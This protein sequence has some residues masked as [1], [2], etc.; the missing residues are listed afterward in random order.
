[1]DEKI[2]RVYLQMSGKGLDPISRAVLTTARYL[3]AQG[4][5]K[6]QGVLFTNYLEENQRQQLLRCGLDEVLIFEGSCFDGFF[7]ELQ[8]DCL[9]ELTQPEIFLFPATPEGRTLS[10]LM[11]ARLYTGVTADCTALSFG[12]EGRLLQ[13]RPAFSGSR[14]ATIL[15]REGTQIASLRFAMPMPEPETPTAL[16]LRHVEKP[17]PYPARWLDHRD[18]AERTIPIALVLGGGIRRK[19]DILDF[20]APPETAGSRKP[21]G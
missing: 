15:T 20:E 9:E 3:G 14:L 10:S 6:T 4:H 18:Q 11:G 21:Q 5:L 19:E 1:M 13:T 17:T 7:P 16:R 2:L 12:E 8:G